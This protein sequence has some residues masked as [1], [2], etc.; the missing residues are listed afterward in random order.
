MHVRNTL[1]YLCFHKTVRVCYDRLVVENL[2]CV[3]LSVPDICISNPTQS[4]RHTYKQR[5]E[6]LQSCDSSL[7]V[8]TDQSDTFVLWFWT[9]YTAR[10]VSDSI[11]E[12]MDQDTDVTRLW[13]PVSGRLSTQRC[14]V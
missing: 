6:S 3:V 4:L 13:V 14:I 10:L 9:E 2:S 8:A 7:G 11:R 12:I 1:Q 5:F